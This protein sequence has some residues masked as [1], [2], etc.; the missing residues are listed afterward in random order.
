MIAVNLRYHKF[1]ALW[2]Q[3]MLTA[4]HRMQGISSALIFLE[5]Y[6]KDGDELLNHIVRVIGD[7]TWFYL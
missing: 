5:G 6:H 1:C 3:K 2:F 7:G 4:A